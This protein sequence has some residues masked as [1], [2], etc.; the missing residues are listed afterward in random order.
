M[1]DKMLYSPIEVAKELGI[2]ITKA[3]QL[4]TDGVIGSVKIGKL[5]KVPHDD[6]V[7]YVQRLTHRRT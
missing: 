4:I 6:L 3:R 5:R 2:G 1:A 7:G